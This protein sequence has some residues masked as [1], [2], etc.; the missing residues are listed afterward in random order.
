MATDAYYDLLG[1]FAVR[2]VRQI[3]CRYSPELAGRAVHYS[4]ELTL[5]AAEDQIFYPER[6]V[7]S[8]HYIG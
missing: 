3:I 5:S 4:S 6:R 1:P 8:R 7:A 2:R